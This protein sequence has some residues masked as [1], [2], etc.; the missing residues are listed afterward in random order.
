M[1]AFVFQVAVLDEPMRPL[2]VA[3]ATLTLAASVAMGA[4]KVRQGRAAKHHSQV[5]AVAGEGG[6][7]GPEA[8]ELGISSTVLGEGGQARREAVEHSMEGSMEGSMQARRE[9]VE[10]TVA[11][12]PAGQ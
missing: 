9:A 7:A 8:V 6:Q 2:S 5:L 4:L 1:L 12:S 11:T 3:G 10:L